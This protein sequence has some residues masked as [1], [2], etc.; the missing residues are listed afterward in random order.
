MEMILLDSI[1]VVIIERMVM[2]ISH[3]EV[4]INRIPIVV[5]MIQ[6][7]ILPHLMNLLIVHYQPKPYVRMRN[8]LSIHHHPM[9]PVT[10][11]SIIHHHHWM[12]L[13]HSSYKFFFFF[14]F[15]CLS[16][17]YCFFSSL[18]LFCFCSL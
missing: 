16:Y 7:D 4:P 6:L 3:L 18:S 17:V 13:L 2:N 5:N 15:A 8:L 12:L 14:L 10:I 1:H 9:N 11:K